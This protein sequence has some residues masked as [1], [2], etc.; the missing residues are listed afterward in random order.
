MEIIAG[1][2]LE[3]ESVDRLVVYISCILAT[4]VWCTI[5]I[6]FRIVTVIRANNGAN[7]R[8]GDYRHVIEV[9]V[10]SSVLH[11]VTL[12]VY[13]ALEVRGNLSRD[14]FDTL[15]V[16]TT[17]HIELIFS[18]YIYLTKTACRE[19]LRLSLPGV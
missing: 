19:L 3:F 15:A 12:I 13:V 8:L 1:V 4:T 5:L 7:S 2:T 18:E 16:I 10:E 14:Y 9:F 11:S 17:V 6:V